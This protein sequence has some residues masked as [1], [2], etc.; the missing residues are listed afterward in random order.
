MITGTG[1]GTYL[2]HVALMK[3]GQLLGQADSAVSVSYSPEYLDLGR[4]DAL[5]R[6]IAH[7][8]SGKVLAVPASAWAQAPLPIPISTDVFWLLVLLVALL[9]PLDVAVRRITLS[10]RQLV[11][12][13]V[14]LARERRS[15]DLEVVVPDELTRLRSRVTSRRR[16]RAAE[17]EQPPIARPQG[18]EG[19]H[20]RQAG[21]E[22]RAKPKP[23]NTTAEERAAQR[24]RQEQEALS[25][26]LL[27]ARKRRRG[28]EE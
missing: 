2:L 17:R 11:N 4:D 13:A 5:L 1:V 14:A 15:A 21:Q 23:A 22:A 12:N 9:W 28:P 3:G 24:R 7:N 16:R 8:G 20:G 6:Q 19:T 18:P 26:R 10:P 27:Q 25:A